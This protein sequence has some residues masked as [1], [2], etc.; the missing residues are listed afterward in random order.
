M[1]IAIRL[2]VVASVMGLLGAAPRPHAVH[3]QAIEDSDGDRKECPGPWFFIKVGN[4]PDITQSSVAGIYTQVPELHDCQRFI[5]KRNWGEEYGALFAVF[6]SERLDR[7]RGD[8]EQANSRQAPGQ[9]Q[10]GSP[11]WVTK[12]VVAAEVHAAGG[13]Y[14]KLGVRPGFNCLYLSSENNWS[15]AYMVWTQGLSKCERNIPVNLQGAVKLN[16]R[17]I[18]YGGYLEEDYPPVARWVHTGGRYLVGLKCGD[19]WC[20]VGGAAQSTA[21]STPPPT[22]LMTAAQRKLTRVTRIPGWHD[23]QRVAIKPSE[24]EIAE[25]SL[26]VM[27]SLVRG[28]AIPD[29]ALGEK[30]Q[31]SEFSDWTPA[32]TIVLSATPTN[33]AT[34]LGLTRGKNTLELKCISQMDWLARITAPGAT[35]KELKVSRWQHDGLKIPGTLRWRWMANDETIWARCLEGCCQVVPT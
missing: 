9:P 17:R 21:A 8:L 18:Q 16:V 33:Y 6:S 5:V 34:K 11:G 4:G 1:R 15:A 30:T 31:C 10:P 23:E 24:S 13:T 2:A 3:P 22:M 7:L 27:P 19:A 25:G 32:G 35:P 28:Q 20:E 29:P 26:G 14:A 12:A